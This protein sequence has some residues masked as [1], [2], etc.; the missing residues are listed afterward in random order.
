MPAMDLA[1][2]PPF[3]QEAEQVV[4]GSMLA[5]PNLIPDVSNTMTSE[6]LY[7]PRHATIMDTMTFLSDEGH[8][9]EPGSVIQYLQHNGEL[10][11]V[12]G[13]EYIVRLY[14]EASPANALYYANIVSE[15]STVRK[16]MALHIQGLNAAQDGSGV[17]LKT[18]VSETQAALD[19]I[20]EER[21]ASE[22]VRVGHTLEGTY[23]KIEE[24]AKSQGGV[25]GVPTGFYELDRLTYGLHPGQMI[26]VAARPGVGKSTLGMDFVRSAAIKHN[27]P[28]L[29]CS[30]EMSVDEI[31]M[32]LLSAE[33][34]VELSNIRKGTVTPTEWD[35]MSRKHQKIADAPLFLDDFAGNTMG[36][37]RQKARR[38]KQRHG[39][40]L[41]IIDYLQLMVAERPSGSRQ[42][43]VSDMSR[44]I[45]LLAKELGCP[46]I[47]MSQLNRGSE[48]RTDPRP[49][50]SDLR[51]S[52]AIE[53][54]ADAIMLIHREDMY[55]PDT[56]RVGEAD[57]IIGKQRSA[58]TGTGVLGFQ[59]GYSR[60]AD[61]A[62]AS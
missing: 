35:R 46:V 5:A 12:G 8:P 22:V 16:I 18:L 21:V 40:G 48:G 20:A 61:L 6:D 25:T 11:K 47:A 4:I 60:F 45:K 3:S 13:R 9:V 34:G 57:I 39:L 53:Q 1:K 2:Q 30:L 28:T 19:S 55:D 36:Q 15:K 37:I 27:I 56:P 32:R 41:I 62:R 38:I 50:V 10:E 26:V 17:D 49:K 7:E 29:M 58:P 54:D 33:C 59:G 24:L 23:D 42:Q 52:G 44:S 51:E 14:R 31:N 43:D